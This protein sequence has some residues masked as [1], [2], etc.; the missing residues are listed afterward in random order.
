[1]A[2]D[3]GTVNWDFHVPVVGDGD[4]DDTSS[5]STVKTSNVDHSLYGICWRQWKRYKYFYHNYKTM[6]GNNN[7]NIINQFLKWLALP[8]LVLAVGLFIALLLSDDDAGEFGAMMEQFARLVGEQFQFARLVGEQFARLGGLILRR[9]RA[10]VRLTLLAIVILI[11]MHQEGKRMHRRFGGVRGGI[12][13]IEDSK[14]QASAQKQSSQPKIDE[15][16]AK[17]KRKVKTV[18]VAQETARKAK[19]PLLE[20]AVLEGETITGFADI[21][22]LQTQDRLDM[23]DGEEED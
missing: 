22:A 14:R 7:N 20:R 10:D 18:A 23:S 5:I 4:D 9:T 2:F 3:C 17:S 1:M 12:L 16:I 15:V 6:V 19:L 8:L 11:L 13:K 21:L